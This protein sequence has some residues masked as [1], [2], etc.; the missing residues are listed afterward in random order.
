MISVAYS[1][2]GRLLF[3]LGLD[4]KV[5]IWDADTFTGSAALSSQIHDKKYFPTIGSHPKEPILVAPSVNPSELLFLRF[6]TEFLER[7]ESAP[8][9]RT[10]TRVKVA[11][12]GNSEVGKTQIANR[13][14]GLDYDP[15][16]TTHGINITCIAATILDTSLVGEEW[17]DR[18]VLLWDLGGQKDYQ[19]IHQLFLHNTSLALLLCDPT[20]RDVA[21]H[22]VET[23]VNKLH[24]QARGT[25]VSKILVGTKVD[26]D[27]GLIVEN[28]LTALTT[29]LGI[30]GSIQTSAKTGNGIA[31]L[32]SAI[33]KAIDWQR[34]ERVVRP[35]LF[36]VIRDKLEELR[37]SG[38]IAVTVPALIESLHESKSV[39]VQD[40]VGRV[41]V[42]AFN[43]VVTQLALQGVIAATRLTDGT[44][45][46]VLQIS[47]IERYAGSLLV[48]ASNNPDGIPAVDELSILGASN[49]PGISEKERL[50]RDQERVVIEAVIQLLLQNGICLRH[51]GMLVFPSKVTATSDESVPGG[52]DELFQHIDFV[53]AIENV[54]ATLITSLSNSRRFGRLRIRPGRVEFVGRGRGICAIGCVSAGP[55]RATLRAYVSAEAFKDDRILFYSYIQEHLG[56]MG[57]ELNERLEV[58]CTCGSVLEDELIRKRLERG[59]GDIVCPMCETR[60]DLGELRQYGVNIDTKLE[61]SRIR[62]AAEDEIREM[63]KKTGRFLEARE[64]RLSSRYINVLHLSDLHISENTDVSSLLTPLLLDLEEQKCHQID[65]LVITGDLT[66]RAARP[67]FERAYQFISSLLEARSITAARTIVVPGNHDVDWDS[68]VYEWYSKRSVTESMLETDFYREEGSGYLLQLRDIYNDRLKNYSDF[69]ETLRLTPFQLEPQRQFTVDT[70]GD[71]EIQFLSFN[72]SAR[73]DEFFRDRSGILQAAVANAIQE[74]HRQAPRGQRVIRI[75]VFHHPA[76]GDER[77]K[78]DGFLTLL[79]QAGVGVCLHGHVHEER[80]DL[81][82]YLDP[83]K[84]HLIGAGTF[85]ATAKHRPE[86]TPRLYNLIRIDLSSRCV[87]IHTRSARKQSGAWDEWCVWPSERASGKQGWYEFELP[88]SLGPIVN[89]ER[90]DDKVR[91]ELSGGP[92]ISG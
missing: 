82:N 69:Y 89:E 6:N 11:L 63:G 44:Q 31:H 76:T 15:G 2:D 20:R 33:V 90:K 84:I 75:G 85:G 52:Y 47:E 21:Y 72:S 92:R 25:A 7:K 4:N 9:G 37:S 46:L 61:A 88:A 87:R 23:W 51:D 60:H 74:A 34:F 50:P 73:I 5:K 65:Y 24:Q 71:D 18:D 12:V 3:S 1:F 14:R 28:E 26:A 8:A 77:I 64:R 29:R 62:A 68:K 38:E 39:D 16:E 55:G 45:V 43:I 80:A 35:G 40:P 54:Y 49:L 81:F 70:F 19:L 32:G 58:R 13:L 78:D 83:R 91:R 10:R 56:R 48:L 41:D 79:Q 53:G 17:S 67:E 66:D 42:G 22:D 57:I 30:D 86:S 27:L 59:N 36:Q